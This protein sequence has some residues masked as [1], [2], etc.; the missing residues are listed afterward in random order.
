[1]V[2]PREQV[3]S[4]ETTFLVIVVSAS[5]ALVL[6]LLLLSHHIHASR[7]QRL[8]DSQATLALEFDLAI[9]GYVAG[10]LRPRVQALVPPDTFEPEVMSS[11]YIARSVFSQVQARVPG[12]VLRFSSTNPRNPL[13]RACPEEERLIEHF[14]THPDE[15]AWQGELVLGDGRYVARAT[16]RRMD[17]TCLQCHG[18]PADAPS[19]L[20]ARYG[21]VAGFGRQA[22]ELVGLD[23]V[24]V[25]LPDHAL[26]ATLGE[27][28]MIPVS[29]ALVTCFAL[30]VLA[31]FRWLVTRRLRLIIAHLARQANPEQLSLDLK[32][33]GGRDEITRLA[34][35]FNELVDTLRESYTSLEE[36]IRAR[37]QELVRAKEQAEAAN[38]A[39]SDFVANMS[40]ELRTPMNGILG[41]SDLLAVT[42]LTPE[43]HRHVET[44]QNSAE[45]LLRL[46]NDL[47]DFSKIEAGRLELEAIDFDLRPML[48]SAL[49]TFAQHPKRD[50]VALVIEI[51]ED[52][53][54]TLRGDPGRVRQMILNLVGNALKFTETGA[55][56]VRAE[57]QGWTDE[58]VMLHFTVSDSGI[59]IAPERIEAIFEAFTQADGSTT[60]RY[61]GTGLGLTITR[62][63][64]QLMG[65]DLWA[66]SE[67]GQGSVFHALVRF[68][69]SAPAALEQAQVLP[70]ALRGL[71]ALLI[72]P[73][74]EHR[75]KL[76]GSLRVWGVTVAAVGEWQ[77]A[78]KATT[79]ATASGEPFTLIL[80]DAQLPGTDAF[81]LARQLRELQEGA[82]TTVVM[83][84]ASGV[85]G[86]ASRC[87]AAGVSVYLSK[88]VELGDLMEGLVMALERQAQGD[89]SRALI[90]R[91][92]IHERRLRAG[93]RR[94]PDRETPRAAA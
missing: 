1:M 91:H 36:S 75:R 6:G 30:A 40:H 16:A 61:G 31:A 39:K 59:G 24:A 77:Q 46:I 15:Q 44:M 32:A 43:Q 27:T 38:R 67:P 10:E 37:T 51:G 41:L 22:G 2:G 29:I 45:S 53:P 52:V 69:A 86:D 76:A 83:L 60:R 63:L 92:S 74:E 57:I 25:P 4:V 55:V 90:T 12:T 66:E 70:N 8:L 84:T 3:R 89:A 20:V 23:L 71:R 42:D 65:G 18:D 34:G 50:Q 49:E 14:R 9:R 26:L 28:H 72:D 54:A 11:S 64:A 21:S 58:G 48:A 87:R 81:A 73:H 68:G 85:R 19:A 94:Q 5:A 82:V 79:L 47:L 33:V 78:L 35:A 88:P 56:R 13:N 17:A 7:E 93:A 62:R 80:V